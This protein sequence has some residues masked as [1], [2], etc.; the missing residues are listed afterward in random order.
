MLATLLL[1]PGCAWMTALTAPRVPLCEGPLTSTEL[2]PDGLRL[3]QQHRVRAGAVD[4]VLELVAEKTSGRLVVVGFS[5]LGA[6]S[7]AVT[8]RG[9]E[10]EVEHFVPFQPVPPENVLRD[11]HR[12]SFSQY[13]PRESAREA[14]VSVRRTGEGPMGRAEILHAACGYR[15]I[16]VTLS[17]EIHRE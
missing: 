8:Q 15:T 6:K 5:V 11:L 3:R 9:L 10:V 1:L 2:I 14:E 16:V 4:L 12:V 13:G 7:F 17:E